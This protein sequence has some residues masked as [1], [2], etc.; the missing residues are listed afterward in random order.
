MPAPATPHPRPLSNPSITALWR[1][2][3]LGAAAMFAAS[4]GAEAA[5][6]LMWPSSPDA[7]YWR[8]PEPVAPR[9][10]KPKPKPWRP[11]AKTEKLEM[12]ARQAAKPQAPVIIAISIDQQHMKVYDAN[13]LFA[14]TPISSGMRGHAT[15]TGVFSIIQKNKYHRSNIY[16][17]APMPYMQRL[18]WS[19]I[20]LHAGV[21]PGYPASHGCVRMP[22][23]FATRLWNWTRMGARVIVTPGE[24]SPTSFSHPLLATRKP[25]PAPV[26][27]AAV[28]PATDTKSDKAAVGPS[29]PA[30]ATAE[31]RPSLTMDTLPPADGATPARRPQVR[32]ADASNSLPRPNV[33]ATLSDANA[34]DAGAETKPA[35]APADKA[36]PPKDQTRASETGSAPPVAEE[37]AAA[38]AP[39]RTGQIAA[40]VSRKDGKLYVRQNFTP[41]FD[42][43]IT[44]SAGDRPLGTHVFTAAAVKDEPATFRWSVVSLPEVKRSAEPRDADDRKARRRQSAGAVEMT[45]HPVPN[46]AAEALD[47]LTIPADAMIRIAEALSSGASLV[48]SDHAVTDGGETGAGT[49]FI[50]P[51]R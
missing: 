34:A 2:S 22:M 3:A 4:S 17:D 33:S 35:T 8:E 39:K 36:E 31:L 16:S 6:S 43:P 24:V 18:T 25:D 44:I 14:E 1:V 9:R 37:P 45:S 46:T 11:D 28:Q 50:V 41:L 51:H 5:T 21:L 47:R 12:Q 26:P 30:A 32:T 13:G 7:G 20:A 15:P 19:G 42:V 27:V 10:P 29:E 49:D 23:S 38:P 48:V 40:F